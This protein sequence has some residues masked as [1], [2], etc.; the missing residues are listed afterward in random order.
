LITE[1]I[2]HIQKITAENGIIF[3]HG[4]RGG[5][6]DA[7]ILAGFGVLCLDGMGP[8]G[9]DAHSSDEYMEID[10]VLPYYNLSM[11]LMK[12]LADKKH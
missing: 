8:I 3:K 6:S 7:N 9:D 2:K 12:D 4:K 1:Y 10:S 5:L 11:L